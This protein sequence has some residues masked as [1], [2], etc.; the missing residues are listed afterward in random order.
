MPY[1]RYLCF[2]R[3]VVSNTYCIVPLICFYSY[4]VPYVANVSGLYLCDCPFGIAN[5][6]LHH[7]KI[8]VHIYHILRLVTTL[9]YYLPFQKKSPHRHEKCTFKFTNILYLFAKLDNYS[10]INLCREMISLY[11]NICSAII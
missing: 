4:C 10:I 2:L 3:I 6:Y 8:T 7:R 1:L 5:F 9:P 11:I